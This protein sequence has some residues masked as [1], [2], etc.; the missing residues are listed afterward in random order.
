[1]FHNISM[2][3]RKTGSPTPSLTGIPGLASS[4][5]NS[6]YTPCQQEKKYCGGFLYTGCDYNLI[7]NKAI[8]KSIAFNWFATSAIPN[9]I[10]A[11]VYRPFLFYFLNLS[12][13][14]YIATGQMRRPFRLTEVSLNGHRFLPNLSLDPDAR[15]RTKNTRANPY[16]SL[17]FIRETSAAYSTWW[18]WKGT[19]MKPPRKKEMDRAQVAAG[20]FTHLRQVNLPRHHSHFLPV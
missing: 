8:M 6:A 20:R 16:A 7:C 3:L 11:L 15:A 19:W 9:I 14:L 12:P 10:C 5:W 18:C 1:M 2:C 13:D 4:L 17:V